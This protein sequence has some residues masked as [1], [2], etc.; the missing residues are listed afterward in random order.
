MK[1]TLFIVSY[2]WPPAGGPGVQ[3]WLK[4]VTHLPKED[5]DIHVIIPENP[6]YPSTDD[7]LMAEIPSGI[8]VTKVAIKEPTRFLKKLFG[9][10][11]KQLQRGF[12]EKKPGFIE[13]ILLWIRGNFFI[14]DARVSWVNKVVKE[15]K[16]D[17]AF[18]KADF[19]ITTGP[20]HSVHLIGLWLKQSSHSTVKWIAD[21]RDPWTTIGYHKSLKLTKSSTAE[22]VRLEQ[23]VLTKAD[24]I[25]VT[26]PATKE[27]FAKKTEKPIAVITNGF[28]LETNDTLQ[29]NGKFTISHIGT[30]LADRDPKTL[31]IALRDIAKN[32]PGFA[33]DLELQLAGNVSDN[34]LQSIK[35]AGL[36][37][38]LQNLGYVSHVKALELMY[39][40]QILLLIEIND[41]DTRVIIPG[42]LF[43]YLASRRP[44]I[45][46]GPADSDIEKILEDTNAGTYFTY[47]G[48][49]LKAQILK[50]YILFKEGKLIGNL[51][52]ISNFHRKQLTQQLMKILQN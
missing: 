38:Y 35:D 5:F 24:Q 9:S 37:N 15:L 43:E 31:W 11:T 8:S 21:F 41:R 23:Q 10:K 47:D 6:D 26:S 48:H 20:P 36:K 39:A 33:A 13:R 16:D 4:F 3:R 14:P 7:S 45:A 22:H 46:I 29:P 52:D 18:A 2:Y 1:E 50:S 25:L 30:L 49:S 32:N 51:S 44:I 34:V 12:I 42:K 19:L 28:D 17:S 40:S 27:E